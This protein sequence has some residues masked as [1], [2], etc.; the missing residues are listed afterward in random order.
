LAQPGK[1]PLPDGQGTLFLSAVQRYDRANHIVS[2]TQFYEVY[3]ADGVMRSKSFVDIH[4]YL[5]EKDAFE[6]LVASEGFEVIHLYG[7]YSRG[8]FEED[9]SP[10]MIWILGNK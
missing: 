6:A 8:A 10:F 4:F 7:D 2:G 1:H 5:H 9:K 3:G